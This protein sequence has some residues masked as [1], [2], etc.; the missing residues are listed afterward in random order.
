MQSANS[1]IDWPLSRLF[2]YLTVGSFFIALIGKYASKAT[3]WARSL[4][5]GPFRPCVEDAVIVDSTG[6]LWCPRH[7]S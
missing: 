1:T 5:D 2:S 7:H 6:H 3:P 4:R